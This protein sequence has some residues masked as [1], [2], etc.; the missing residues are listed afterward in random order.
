MYAQMLRG[1]AG[2]PSPL[3]FKVGPLIPAEAHQNTTLYCPTIIMSKVVFYQ[4]L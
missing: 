4:E 3:F 1:I 2:M